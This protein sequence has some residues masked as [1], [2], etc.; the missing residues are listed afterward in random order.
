M[1]MVTVHIGVG[2]LIGISALNQ[3]GEE[4]RGNTYHCFIWLSWWN[5]YSKCWWYNVLFQF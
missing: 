4:V 1:R 2:K 3:G 5:L